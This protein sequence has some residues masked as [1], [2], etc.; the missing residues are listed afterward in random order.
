MNQLAVAI[1]QEYYTVDD[2]ELES[3]I[4]LKNVVV[5]YKTW[6][7]LNDSRDNVMIICHAFTGSSNVED[8]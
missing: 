7:E 3:G 6:G 1:E 4:H 2:F 5:A 8:W